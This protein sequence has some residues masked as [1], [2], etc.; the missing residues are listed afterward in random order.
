MRHGS[1]R[2]GVAEPVWAAGI[3]KTWPCEPVPAVC[4]MLSL[5]LLSIHCRHQT[6]HVVYS[7][8]HARR[9]LKHGAWQAW[10]LAA[11]HGS[12]QQAW[13]AAA[14]RRQASQTCHFGQ[15]RLAGGM[16]AWRADP[17]MRHCMSSWYHLCVW[18]CEGKRKEAAQGEHFHLGMA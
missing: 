11:W 6:S 4:V 16:F 3:R 7:D 8:R 2:R 1:W 14:W 18:S 5:L 12:R 9:H 15:K 13:Q 17:D 10:R